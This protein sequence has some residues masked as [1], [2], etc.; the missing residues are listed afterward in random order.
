MDIEGG[1][2]GTRGDLLCPANRGRRVMD[3]GLVLTP[4][5]RLPK[6]GDGGL[7]H[8]CFVASRCVDWERAH[9]PETPERRPAVGEE[10]IFL[11]S[12]R[13]ELRLGGRR[14][15][16]SPDSEA[17]STSA[18]LQALPMHPV[19]ALASLP[20]I[21]APVS[22][23][24]PAPAQQPANASLPPLSIDRS[25]VQYQTGPDGALWARGANYKLRLD[26]DGATYLPFF[27]SSAPQDYALRFALTQATVAGRPLQLDGSALPARAGDE[28]RFD[29]GPIDEVYRI[30]P[31]Q[32]EQ[33]FVVESLPARGELELRVDLKSDLPGSTVADGF[34]FASELGRVEYG[35]ATAVDAL[36]Q[37]LELDCRLETDAISIRVPAAFVEGARLPL[38]ID[39]Y[40]LSFGVETA[41]VN[42]LSGDV[43]HS[44]G[45][46]FLASWEEAFSAVDHDVY[47][48][49]S[50]FNGSL[51]HGAYVDFT[52]ANWAH[53]RS[54]HVTNGDRFLVAAQ[55]GSAT[56]G[57]R[58]IW[59]VV[60]DPN[61]TF[62]TAQFQIS[63]AA[64][65]GDLLNP[66][67]GGSPATS[68]PSYFCV[69]YER[70]YNATDH[71]IHAQ[72]VDHNG[73]PQAAT[74]L[75]D[76]SA[77][78]LDSEPSISKSN[79]AQQWI[80]VWQRLQ[81]P[82]D[83]DVE[84]ARI[85]PTGALVPTYPIDDYP[86]VNATHPTV[87]S[88]V[89]GTDHYMVAY[90]VDFQNLHDIW[91]DYMVDEGFQTLDFKLSEQPGVNPFLRHIE[92]NLDCNGRHVALS[93]C[94][95]HFGS[96]SDYDVAIA[97]IL[98]AAWD[99]T[100]SEPP[101][102]IGGL[103]GVPDRAPQTV[104][105]ESG[106]ASS[107]STRWWTIYCQQSSVLGAGHSDDLWVN[108]YDGTE[109][110]VIDSFCAGT[111][112]TCPCSNGGFNG[113]GC[114]NSYSPFGASLGSYSGHA[115]TANDT[116]NLQCVHLP[117]NK[118]ALLFQGYSLINSGFGTTFGDGVRCIGS[119]VV[120]FQ[121]RAADSNG[122]VGWGPTFGD[123]AIS[124][125]G[126][127][128]LLGGVWCYQVWYRDPAVFCGSG[129]TNFSN[130]V[131]VHWTP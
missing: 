48:V 35:R 96:T 65:A 9:G 106:D 20:L 74:L 92:P 27:S 67:V 47:A 66:D 119:P 121:A 3:R 59:G 115:S 113:A 56:G 50:D 91:V 81:S 123:P 62:V 98:P 14:A 83:G 53:P 100:L 114:A 129:N 29:R 61:L 57:A 39:P 97:E 64:S 33:L 46:S 1:Q 5:P 79:D 25:I 54:A 102:M 45:N 75:V 104:S 10:R 72:L 21:L 12:P 13:R 108:A 107:A 22:S 37:T 110:G 71:D 7:A 77:F 8:R 31:H 94:E 127:I 117:P 93:Y 41:P 11:T 130:A 122:S 63:G 60:R 124:A 30:A 19:I 68:S 17:R 43:S 125:T 6:Q 49:L 99:L 103:S 51:S 128:P 116:L 24:A 73:I 126:G 118:S 82:G 88:L 16:F 40:V 86:A 52:N 28:V 4:N 38:V 112:S 109:G 76:D 58:K 44:T 18:T 131:R 15:H 55:V 105:H 36:G 84:A 80:V 26:S 70:I 78:T 89:Q 69:A 34:E 120:R 87:S 2:V 85:S 95:L 101:V 42:S 111:N 90:E 23:A 32:L